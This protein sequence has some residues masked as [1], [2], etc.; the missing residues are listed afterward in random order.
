VYVS[1]E[2]QNLLHVYCANQ[3]GEEIELS[4][5]FVKETLADTP[6]VKRRQRSG[7]IHVHPNGQTVYVVNRAS[8]VDE[9]DGKE[10][11]IGGENNIAVYKINPA[12]GEPT[13]TQHAD[14]RGV[15]ARTFA[16]DASGEFLIA[17]NSQPIVAR[18]G[19]ELVT[20]PASLAVFRVGGDGKLAYVGKTDV[21][22]SAAPMFWMGVVG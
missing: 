11:Y 8:G 13:V 17:S 5:A 4:P 15:V 18:V 7:T 6:G 9:V 12:T 16:L 22:A 21:D 2:L 19:G 14:T 1:L 10:V 20:V 3:S